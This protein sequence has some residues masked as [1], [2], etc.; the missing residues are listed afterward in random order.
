MPILKIFALLILGAVVGG[1]AFVWLLMRPI[2]FFNQS[3]IP[4]DL[5]TSQ[6]MDLDR[7]YMISSFRSGAGHD[8]SSGVTGETCRSMKHY[9][10]TSKFNTSPPYRSQPTADEPNIKIYA[11]FDG[12]ITDLKPSHTGIEV[13]M[14]SNKY[15]S[16]RVRIFHVDPLS[17]LKAGSKVKS[18]QWIATI[19]PKDGT[20]FSVEAFSMFNGVILLSYFEVMTDEVFKPYQD[21]GFKREDFIISKEYRDTHPFKC[22]GIQTHPL[23]KAKETFQHEKNRSWTEDYIYLRADPYPQPDQQE[24]RIGPPER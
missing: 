18:G 5:I 21:M 23:N 16:Y 12:K 8:F 3:Q 13:T 19:G 11:P 9:F 15:P 1:L 2:L 20:D 14:F 17:D 24:V 4:N 6:F 22:G 7:V 10:N